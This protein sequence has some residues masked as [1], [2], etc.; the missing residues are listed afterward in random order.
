MQCSSCAQ[1]SVTSV[2]R[3][4]SS[5][6]DTLCASC[7]SAWQALFGGSCSYSV[8]E[9]ICNPLQASKLS[10]G[11]KSCS[12]ADV[13][14]PLLA[15]NQPKPNGRAC[16]RA[17]ERVTEQRRG[18]YQSC[19]GVPAHLAEEPCVRPCVPSHQQDSG[20]GRHFRR[21]ARVSDRS[22]ARLHVRLQYAQLS[23]IER[24]WRACAIALGSTD[25]LLA[26]SERAF[27]QLFSCCTS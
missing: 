2:L 18:A 5:Q 16:E 8:S 1:P 27:V 10:R 22:C 23:S 17:S 25:H 11:H 12:T 14:K 7:C 3:S 9:P 4:C 19:D 26:A 20:S 6:R 21:C 15:T 13:G 24:A